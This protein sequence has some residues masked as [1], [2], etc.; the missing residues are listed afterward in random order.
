MITPLNFVPL[1]ELTNE[2]LDSIYLQFDQYFINR[3]EYD[4]FM[5]MQVKFYPRGIMGRDLTE[6]IANFALTNAMNGLREKLGP[7]VVKTHQTDSG[8]LFYSLGEIGIDF[9]VDPCYYMDRPS[10]D[11]N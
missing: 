1:H 8:D 4:Q 7:G 2:D 6:N 10:I 5:N 3:G 9:G 11:D